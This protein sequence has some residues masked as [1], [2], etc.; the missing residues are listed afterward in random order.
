DRATTPSTFPRLHPPPLLPRLPSRQR[1]A[2]SL[3]D[4]AACFSRRV[5][6]WTT[7]MAQESALLVLKCHLWPLN[8]SRFSLQRRLVCLIALR[9]ISS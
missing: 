3:R 9:V 2:A 1:R 6:Q 5:A 7:T 8:L 4:L